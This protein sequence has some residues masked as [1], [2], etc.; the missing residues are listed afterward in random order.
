MPRDGEAVPTPAVTGR[1]WFTAGEIAERRLPGLPATRQ[2]V[3]A[4]ADR[5]RWSRP[6]WENTHWR[7]RQGRGG[8]VEYH[9]AC[10]PETARVHLVFGLAARGE[11]PR[12]A[13]AAPAPATP[14][15]DLARREGEW[16]FF[17]R[18]PATKKA[19]A[20]RRLEALS[21]VETLERGGHS[22]TDAMRD[23]ALRLRVALSTLYR[24]WDLVAGRNEGDWLPLLAPKHCGSAGRDKECHPL[25]WSHL[26]GDYLR[27]ERPAFTSCYERM[28]RRAAAEGWAPIPAERTLLRRVMQI[29]EAQRVLARDGAES[30]QRLFPAQRRD[31][32]VFHSMEAVNADGHTWDVFVRWPDGTVGRPSMVAFQDLYSGKI[33]SWRVDR[34]LSWHGVRL[35]FG[36]VVEGF[37]IPRLCWLDN[38][39]EFAAKRITGGQANRYRFKLREE[40]PEGLLTA[41]GVEVHWTTPYHGQA[42]PIERAFRDFAERIAKHPVFSG[43]YTGNTPMAKPENYASKAVKLDEFVR[44]VGEEIAAHNARPGRRSPT[45]AGRSFDDTFAASL[46]SGEALVRRATAEQRRLWLLA[47]EAVRVRRVDG[48]IHLMGNRYWGE[49]LLAHRGGTVTARFDP[50]DLAEPLHVYA[51]DGRY[52]G[53]AECQEA[54]GFNSVAAAQEHARKLKIFRRATRAANEALGAMAIQD[55]ARDLPRI[56]ASEPPEPKLVRPLFAGATALKPMPLPE[57]DE[58][59][60]V[61]AAI[62]ANNLRR[63]GSPALRI[64]ADEDDDDA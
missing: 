64:V 53:A 15:A 50:E 58:H 39:R 7:A 59:D 30:L 38:G 27:P 37:G 55:I 41:L 21:L 13:A 31:R 54:V 43:A 48:Q 45:C 29:P 56:E 32:G 49:F 10:L 47:A 26:L 17:A 25:A 36:D 14:A 61:M 12:R 4:I 20:Q 34:A 62:A 63:A 44:V 40:E 60:P 8:G 35:A 18:L 16:E 46:S 1:E 57:A 11:L 28:A 19:E 51:N 24:W 5:R 23:T 3:Q 22:R 52:L 42:K 9:L 6:E 2:G 33:L